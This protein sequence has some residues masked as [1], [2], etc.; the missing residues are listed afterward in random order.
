[1]ESEA[2]ESDWLMF[3]KAPTFILPDR[4]LRPA[5]ERDSGF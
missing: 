4:G 3:S 5:S 2:L 1:M